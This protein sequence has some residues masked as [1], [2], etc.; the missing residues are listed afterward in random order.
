MIYSGLINYLWWFLRVNS[1]TTI[2]TVYAEMISQHEKGKLCESRGRKVT[3]LKG[4]CPRMAGLPG[5][6]LACLPRYIDDYRTK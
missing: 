2:G 5:T 1:A 3:D 4:K 6:L